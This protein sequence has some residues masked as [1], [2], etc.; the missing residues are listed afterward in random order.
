MTNQ[1]KSFP[2]F[3]FFQF[4]CIHFFPT[5]SSV[6][7]KI[8]NKW[9][10]IQH[11]QR[12]WD[13]NPREN[14]RER[15]GEME[16]RLFADSANIICTLKLLNLMEMRDRQ[17]ANAW[18]REKEIRVRTGTLLLMFGCVEYC[19]NGEQTKIEASHTL[20]S[21]FP[22]FSLNKSFRFF[23]QSEQLARWA[24]AV[25][26]K[27]HDIRYQT[28]HKKG[29]L[30]SMNACYVLFWSKAFQNRVPPCFS[31]LR[32][33]IQNITKRVRGFRCSCSNASFT[34]LLFPIL[35]SKKAKK[36]QERIP[37]KRNIN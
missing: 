24:R 2:I 13:N 27:L 4:H 26:L 37:N 3:F 34:V 35:W 25:C 8:K 17:I 6:Q 33:S 5:P 28:D 18:V 31:L 14:D 15:E 1:H 20:I 11:D 12:I 21:L 16:K 23:F 9:H 29:E 19:S 22:L 30:K 10:N 36:N 7:P 32:S